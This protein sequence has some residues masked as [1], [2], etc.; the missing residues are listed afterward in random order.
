MAIFESCSVIRRQVLPSIMAIVFDSPEV[1][2][3]VARWSGDHV[4]CCWIQASSRETVRDFL[5]R[6]ENVLG[7]KSAAPAE[8]LTLVNLD[9][10]NAEPFQHDRNFLD[11]IV[12]GDTTTNESAGEFSPKVQMIRCVPFVTREVRC[13]H[14]RAP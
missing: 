2:V 14:Q 12:S 13:A 8:I 6:H 9:A 7:G 3:I 5:L 4:M 1:S 10:K 11:Q